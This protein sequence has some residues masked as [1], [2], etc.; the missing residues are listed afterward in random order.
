MKVYFKKT[1][2]VIRVKNERDG[3]P[4]ASTTEYRK[5]VS[6]LNAAEIEEYNDFLLREA[7]DS[8]LVD[9]SCMLCAKSCGKMAA[10]DA[11]NAVCN[12]H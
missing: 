6:E 9:A 7:M 2:G 12:D 11:I 1:G 8:Q 10:K 3:R 4:Y 5:N